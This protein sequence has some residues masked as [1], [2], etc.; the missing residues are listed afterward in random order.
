MLW[1][2]LVRDALQC[3]LKDISWPYE[4]N[5]RR[6]SNVL[7]CRTCRGPA[8]LKRF[9]SSCLGFF[10]PA[11]SETAG[12]QYQSYFWT[13]SYIS[14]GR[15]SAIREVILPCLV[16]SGVVAS[17]SFTTLWADFVDQRAKVVP[18]LCTTLSWFFWFTVHKVC[19]RCSGH[20]I[21]T[22]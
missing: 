1:L 19:L 11:L 2:V 7:A 9:A 21:L 17:L 22:R 6:G 12:F 15:S 3:V 18:S 20:I 13:Y 14:W 8:S 16:R 4:L 10:L 5:A